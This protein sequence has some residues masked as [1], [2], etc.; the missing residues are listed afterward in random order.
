MNRFRAGGFLMVMLIIL[1][2][3]FTGSA[4]YFPDALKEEAVITEAQKTALSYLHHYG[5]LAFANE[6][7]HFFFDGGDTVGAFLHLFTP[8][9]RMV[10]K[11]HR[12]KRAEL[13]L[14]PILSQIRDLPEDEL[15]VFYI[16]MAP[17]PLQATDLL[18]E[19]YIPATDETIK[20][21]AVL[22]PL[23]F[24]ME[25]EMNVADIEVDPEEKIV[26]E[27]YCGSHC[28]LTAME[29]V[30]LMRDF[31]QDDGKAEYNVRIVSIL[32]EDEG[33]RTIHATDVDL[34]KVK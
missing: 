8:Y 31:P 10:D 13:G 5:F 34:S 14:D 22:E 6:T 28:Y 18:L 30:F 15:L 4:M 21:A 19:F 20:P 26:I 24:P 1:V 27:K 12:E 9:A 17:M 32:N 33:R 3:S 2:F 29:Y 7:G 25:M 11:M 23:I 16:V